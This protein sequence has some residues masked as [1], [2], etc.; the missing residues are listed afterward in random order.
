MSAALEALKQTLVLTVRGVLH[1]FILSVLGRVC[2]LKRE[3][4]TE[5]QRA[6][7]R[8]PLNMHDMFSGR[9]AGVAIVTGVGHKPGGDGIFDWLSGGRRD[10]GG[11][12]NRMGRVTDPISATPSL[13]YGPLQDSCCA[14]ESLFFCFFL[15]INIVLP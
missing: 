10:R 1:H 14:G 13:T 12:Q 15:K 3:C 7:I 4:K 9:Q 6:S 5:R 8:K 2:L 11:A